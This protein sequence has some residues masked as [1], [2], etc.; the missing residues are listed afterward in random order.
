LV[1]SIPQCS[2]YSCRSLRC[3][4]HHNTEA[5]WAHSLATVASNAAQWSKHDRAGA[6]RAQRLLRCV[7]LPSVQRVTDYMGHWRGVDVS[8]SDLRRVEAITGPVLASLRGK[9][10]QRSTPHMETEVRSTERRQ[11]MAEVDLAFIEGLPFVVAVLLGVEHS[12]DYTLAY[13]IKD[14]GADHIAAALKRVV[15]E[16]ARNNYTLTALRSDGEKGLLRAYEPS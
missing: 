8:S 13:A 7:G 1:V 16:C 2:W 11:T 14:K 5:S 3:I 10:T 4:E 6:V 9:T 12:L 15:G